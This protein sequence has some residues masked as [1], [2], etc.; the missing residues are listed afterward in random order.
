MSKRTP[1]SYF[2]PK[3]VSHRGSAAYSKC[4]RETCFN[5]CALQIRRDVRNAI[6][7]G[8]SIVLFSN[9]EELNGEH[10]TRT[11]S[12]RT[13]K[14]NFCGRDEGAKTVSLKFN[15]L[16]AKT[17]RS[18]TQ[19]RHFTHFASQ[20]LIIVPCVDWTY[21]TVEAANSMYSLLPDTPS[22]SFTLRKRRFPGSV[23]I[24]PNWRRSVHAFC[25]CNLPIELQGQFRGLCL[26][27]IAFPDGG[28]W[29]W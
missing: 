6:E 2:G 16:F 11:T 21:K 14:R 12:P 9:A 4:R 29:R 8:V 18:Y 20:E 28:D 10:H 22:N 24:A 7:H 23:R 25:L 13:R 5:F 19:T 1:Q 3:S 27:K 17:K 15:R 26:W